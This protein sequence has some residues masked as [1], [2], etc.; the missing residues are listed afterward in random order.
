MTVGERVVLDGVDVEIPARGVTVVVGPSGSGKSTLLRLCNRLAAPTSG[1]ILFRGADLSGLD[2]LAHRRMVGMVFQQPTPFGGSVGDNLRV[3]SAE[4]DDTVMRRALARAHLPAAFLDRPAGEL[5]GG[6]SQ[7]ACLARTL[8]TNPEVLLM[9]EPTS[10]LDGEARHA[11]EA[12]ALE[13]AGDGVP[14]VWV[15]HDL[16]QA[17][18]LA[19]WVIVLEE[20]RVR[21]SGEP[22]A[23]A[24]AGHVG[25][26][27]EPHAG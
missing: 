17:V 3:A 15:T 11:L 24:V 1:R 12:L 18:R 9:D 14:V 19:G 10:A 26:G 23:A 20:G 27:S 25:R 2:P 7:R 21:A 16:E 8:I 13:L 22:T 5:S 4:A 6:E